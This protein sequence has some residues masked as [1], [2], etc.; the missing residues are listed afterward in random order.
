MSELSLV[1]HWR[2]ALR[3]DRE[4]DRTATLVGLVLSTYMNE[5][6][7][8]WPAKT[9][10]AAG[11]KLLG[12][13]DKRTEK[14]VARRSNTA[15]SVAIDRLEAAGYLVVLRRRGRNGFTYG[16]AI[17]RRAEGFKSH[18]D[19]RDNGHEIP[20]GWDAKSHA[21]LALIPRAGVDE[22]AESAESI[23]TARADA[24]Q[25]KS[26][27]ARAAHNNIDLTAYDD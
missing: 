26:R 10:I 20:R 6:G 11:A 12:R 23:S 2:N 13:P 3:D 27:R 7:V 17:P 8:A 5:D 21:D 15:V 14:L 1:A 18:A 4:L 22:S 24:R 19:A 16:A 9:T 25:K